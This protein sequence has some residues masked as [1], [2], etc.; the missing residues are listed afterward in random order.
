[1]PRPILRMTGGRVVLVRHAESSGLD[2][3][4]GLTPRGLTDAHE[5]AIALREQPFDRFVASPY[6][7]ARETLEIVA[8]GAETNVDDRLAEWRLP[9]IPDRN[10]PGAM[11]GFFVADAVLPPDAEP[12]ADACRRGLA[13]IRDALHATKSAAMLV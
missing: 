5:L 6:R 3:E 8:A 10:W 7:R 1:M 11:R 13:A 4:A 2:V 12:R 9:W